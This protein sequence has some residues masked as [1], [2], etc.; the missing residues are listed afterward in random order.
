[1]ASLLF[2]QNDFDLGINS[3]KRERMGIMKYPAMGLSSRRVQFRSRREKH[4]AWSL[5]RPPRGLICRAKNCQKREQHTGRAANEEFGL[6]FA[7][8]SLIAVVMAD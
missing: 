5:V 4:A 1:M 3:V 6:Q 7:F 2:L 8:N